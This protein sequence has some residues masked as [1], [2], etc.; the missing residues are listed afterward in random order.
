MG[1]ALTNR[2]L[3]KR[4]QRNLEEACGAG[5]SEAARRCVKPNRPMRSAH[6]VEE[7]SRRSRSAQNVASREWKYSQG[8]RRIQKRSEEMNRDQVDNFPYKVD[9]DSKARCESAAQKMPRF[10]R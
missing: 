3:R 7:K 5:L 2:K 6:D 1:V 9:T 4:G 10:P 8:T